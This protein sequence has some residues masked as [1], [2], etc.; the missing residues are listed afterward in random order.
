MG[1]AYGNTPSLI[2]SFDSLDSKWTIHGSEFGTVSVANSEC[3]IANTLGTASQY[4]GISSVDTF[5]IGWHQFVM[6]YNDNAG[7]YD[8][9][10]DGI[11]RSVFIASQGN[12]G[13]ISTDRVI[14]GAPADP[15][16]ISNPGAAYYG[17]HNFSQILLYNKSL[18]DLEIEQNFNATR[19]RYGI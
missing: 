16:T 11:Q 13:V 14:I 17:R 9:F 12:R 1:I 2:D 8:F 3:T 10:L 4:I 6:R 15:V 7:I 18:T 5:P 19:S